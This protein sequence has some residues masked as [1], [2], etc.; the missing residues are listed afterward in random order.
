MTS[1]YSIVINRQFPGAR[2]L[3]F[4]EYVE[5][6]RQ[7]MT[8]AGLAELYSDAVKSE[9]YEN[10]VLTALRG[11]KLGAR[12]VVQVSGWICRRLYRTALGAY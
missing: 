11:Q 12:C 6:A 10:C 4:E 7:A 9:G 2:M 8:I 5:N 3:R 1:R